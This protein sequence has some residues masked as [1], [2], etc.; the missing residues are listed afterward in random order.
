MQ[1]RTAS[2]GTDPI[3]KT[4]VRL[5]FPTILAQ[6]VNALYSIIDRIYIGHI[7]DSGALA[8][9]GVGISFP[10]IMLLGAFSMLIG[11]GG[12]P[13]ASI[14][15][16][17]GKKRDADTL[18]SQAIGT[19]IILAVVLILFFQLTK[20]PLLFAFGASG[21]TISYS[22]DYMGIYLWGTPFVMFSLGLNPFI[23]AQGFSKI[24]MMTM[25]LGSV[26]NI[27]LDPI[28]IFTL[29][30][31]V[32]GAAFATVISQ[33]VSAIWVIGF[34]TS[35]RSTLTINLSGMMPTKR[36]MLPVLAL[37][38]SPF[39]MMSTESLVNIILNTTLQ[40]T[41]GDLAVGAMSILSSVMLFSLSPLQGLT[42]GGQPLLSYNFGA[43]NYDRVRATFTRI[44][45]S[46]A[47]FSTAVC[48]VLV[49]F[50][51]SVVR[52]FTSDELLIRTASSAMRIFSAGFWMLGFQIACQQA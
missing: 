28:F 17:Q 40:R 5:A 48:L 31:G 13:Q 37:G 15:L 6:L 11:A 7:P 52:L 10:I 35:K 3:G 44:L 38:I 20:R 1:Q 34:L 51:E 29:G 14:K 18:L 32:K 42:Q 21:Q 12:A 30:W 45:I 47:L 2:L 19:L 23:T 50:P 16:G 25:V 4:L 24:S 41:G 26:I 27:I 43:G 39:F 9:T 8:L 22:M 33:A 36:V 49:L 46:S